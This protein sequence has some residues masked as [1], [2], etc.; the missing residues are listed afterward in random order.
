MCTGLALSVYLCI[1]H[2]FKAN[3]QAGERRRRHQTPHN[4]LRDRP[5]HLYWNE[6]NQKIYEREFITIN[7]DSQSSHIHLTNF[8][9]CIYKMEMI[10]GAAGECGGVVS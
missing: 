10:C 4:T 2:K 5:F 7:A 3:I 6:L 8:Q 1:V 9:V